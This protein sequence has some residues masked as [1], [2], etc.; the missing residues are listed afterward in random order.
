LYNKQ[1]VYL[2]VKYLVKR[3]ELMLANVFTGSVIGIDG[4]KITAEVD[5]ISTIPSF[6]IVGL[7]DAAVSES[8]ER[9]R[10]A[11]KNSGYEFPT[12]K[13][14]VNLAPAD[15]KKEGSGFDLPMAVGVLASNGDIDPEKLQDVG[16]IGELSL[17][18][19][20][21][22]VS[23]VLPVAFGLMQSGIKKLVLSKDNAAEAALVEGLEV[24]PV[25]HL[26]EVV[27]FFNPDTLEEFK[28]Q[29]FKVDIKEYLNKSFNEE[30]LFDFK[31][32]KGQEKAKRALEIAAAGGHNIL[33][34][35]TPG[36]G[37]TLLAKCFSGILPPLEFSEA[38]E[39]T[40]IYSVSGLLDKNTYLI[41][42]RPFRSPHHSAS[43]VGIIGGGANPKPGEISL[44]HRGVLFL[45]EVVEFPR[46]VLEVLR[47]PLED[48]VVTISRAQ[49]SVK[50][51]ADFI[52]LA[53]MNPCP[54]GFYGDTQ[55]QCSCSEFQSKRYW[56]KLSGPLLDRIDI[57]IEVP[58]LKEQE[59][60]SQTSSGESS[61]TIRERVIK[62]RQIQIKRFKEDG[63]LSNSQITPKLI[64]KYC[65]L[66]SDCENLLRSAISRLNLSARAYDRILKLSRTIADL[67]ASSEIMPAHIAE[68]IQYRSLDRE[69]MLV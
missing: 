15:I 55:K 21:R 22:G 69:S 43:A 46:D 28:V 16:F 48:G 20:I 44:A 31:D 26:C 24:Y 47:Q 45:D 34:V 2:V 10:S 62:A 66:N 19:Y 7:P 59:L 63:I 42:S 38:I 56:S 32:V 9:I 52:L 25:E 4:Y 65:K 68:A 36:S 50:Y 53:A 18:G 33:M 14:V 37:K 61:K 8:K 39:M 58:R 64:K 67:Q 35:G 17:N 57:Q 6:T 11:I 12:K 60:L 27:D 29:P 54:C 5:T 23:G 1:R 3:V 40:K 30:P 49:L 51:P 13:I 41:T